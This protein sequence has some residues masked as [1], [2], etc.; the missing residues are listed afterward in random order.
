MR[1]GWPYQMTCQEM[2]EDLKTRFNTKLSSHFDVLD[3]KKRLEGKAQ[4]GQLVRFTD[5]FGMAIGDALLPVG[6]E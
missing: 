4:S 2:A 6:I 3:I 5:V 1:E